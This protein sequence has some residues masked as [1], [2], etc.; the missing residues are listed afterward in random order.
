[1]KKYLVIFKNNTIKR[2]WANSEF[3]VYLKYDNI[4][5]IQKAI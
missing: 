3:D 4:I 2:V 5:A 1:M